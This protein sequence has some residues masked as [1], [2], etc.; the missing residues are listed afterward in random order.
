MLLSEKVLDGSP[1]VREKLYAM[2]GDKDMRVRY[3]LAFTLG[4]IPGPRATAAMGAIIARNV[5]YGWIRLAVLSSSLGRT[6]ELFAILADDRKY[7]S[8]DDGRKFLEQL[9]EQTGLQNRKD[10]VA[11]V[12]KML[13]T[14]PDKEIS[15]KAAELLGGVK[16]ARR[17]EIVAAYN[18]VLDMKGDRDRG[19]AVFKKECSTCHMLE[20]V[21]FDLGLPLGSIKNRGPETI[22][23]S[24]LDPNREVQPQYL[25]YVCVTDDGLSVTGMIAAESATSIT[26]TR[27][28]GESDTVLRTNIDELANS[29][30]SIMPEGLE[31]QLSKN[32]MADLIEYLMSVQ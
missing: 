18:D 4:K 21:G 19:K 3:Q 14:F 17:E 9:A 13:N 31:K 30:M 5:N 25:N 32:D 2:T 10:Q 6:G 11:E 7:R 8:T 26:L 16:L 12:L 27:A 22:L 23:I 1:A 15:K 28:E 20:N 24:T 29:G